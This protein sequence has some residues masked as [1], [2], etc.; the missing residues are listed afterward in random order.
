M[1]NTSLPA[2]TMHTGYDIWLEMPNKL[3][4]FANFQTDLPEINT[5]TDFVAE[6]PK[7]KSETKINVYVR[8]K[9]TGNGNLF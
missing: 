4:G 6:A 9:D 7:K 5:L 1:E 2:D 3:K 8:R